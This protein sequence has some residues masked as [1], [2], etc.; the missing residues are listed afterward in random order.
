[1]I[2]IFATILY[3]A[4]LLL[5]YQNSHGTV[6]VLFDFFRW[7]STSVKEA[8]TKVIVAKTVIIINH[9]AARAKS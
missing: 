5:F 4:S 1:M 6:S 7:N 3:F 9:L 2:T 8:S